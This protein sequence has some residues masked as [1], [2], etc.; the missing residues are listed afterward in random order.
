MKRVGSEQII[1][2]NKEDIIK[3]D[4]D[5]QRKMRDRDESIRHELKTDIE[6]STAGNKHIEDIIHA[7]QESD[8]ENFSKS[9]FNWIYENYLNKEQ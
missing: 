5:L 7:L 2:R 6:I 9:D 4:T 1:Q 8:K 3:L